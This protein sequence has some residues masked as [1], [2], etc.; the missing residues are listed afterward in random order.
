M[1]DRDNPWT[2]EGPIRILK[3]GNPN[4]STATNMGIW[5]RN[6]E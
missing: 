3:I 4:A 6:A 1:G 5:Q 2:L